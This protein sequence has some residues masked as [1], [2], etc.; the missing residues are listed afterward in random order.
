MLS[1]ITSGNFPPHDTSKEMTAKYT[2]FQLEADSPV[3]T[4][5][6][7]LA[8]KQTCGHHNAHLASSFHTEVDIFKSA[9]EVEWTDK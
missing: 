5:T 7:E 2:S 6:V 1:H 3:S 4:G 8:G 9:S